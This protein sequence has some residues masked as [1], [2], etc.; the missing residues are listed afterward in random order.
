MAAKFQN[1][2]MAGKGR[3]ARRATDRRGLS[4]VL[5][6]LYLVLF[7]TLAVGFYAGTVISGQISRN[8][9]CTSQSQAASD[10]GMQFIRYQLGSITIAPTVPQDQYLNTVCSALATQLNG[11]SNMNGHSV[12]VS[13]DGTQSCIFI[14]SATDYMTVDSSMGTKFKAKITQSGAFLVV[15]VDGGGASGVLAR[16]VQAKYQKAPKAGMILNY[17]V[18]T[19]GTV[20][21]GGSTIIQGLTDDTKGS[22]LS[23][24]MTSPTP[25][26]IGG[27]GITG[28]VSVVNPA[29]TVSG[30]PIGKTSDP[31]LMQTHIHKGVPLPTFPTIDSSAFQD[32]AKTNINTVSG[33]PYT[34]VYIPPN[35][36]FRFKAGDVINGVL[37]VQS[38][39]VITFRGSSTINGVIV[40]DV[41]TDPTKAFNPAA[42][43]ISFAGNVTAT[44]L[45]SLP[46]SNPAYDSKLVALTGSFLLAPDYQVSFT[47]NFGTVNGSIVAGQVSMS[48]NA[49]GTVAGSLIGMQDVGMTLSG[50]ASITIASTGT[51]QYPTGINFGN[52]FTPLPGTYV[53]VTPW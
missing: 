34:N 6:M 41:N 35:T 40:T 42:N 46:T 26:T 5:A 29:A 20:S 17:G 2:V 50:N 30:G 8:E 19:K 3:R 38:P 16:A 44:P 43:Q 14:P 27:S 32:F 22:V 7:S 18:A 49:G 53:E 39:N 1:L 45:Q 4:S 10:S 31:V 52:N 25:V 51:S 13:S 24:D 9:R 33:S 48:G 23:T 11:T 12:V 15:A 21:T 37:W 36:N 47:G 28:D